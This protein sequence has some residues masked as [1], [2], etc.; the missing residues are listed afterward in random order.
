M[1]KNIKYKNINTSIKNKDVKLNKEKK[2]IKDGHHLNSK[3]W[4]NWKNNLPSLPPKLEAILI[5]MVLSDASMYRVS[6]EAFIKFEQGYLQEQFL[7]HL[8]D[9][10][11]TY[12]FMDSPG[13]RFEL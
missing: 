10:F 6:K 5:G 7:Y 3:Y 1:K 2:M 11:K 8:F 9:V 4:Q 12:C 13:K